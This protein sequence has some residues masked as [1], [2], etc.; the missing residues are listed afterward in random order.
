MG[1]EVIL[2]SFLNKIKQTMENEL[3]N[4][5]EILFSPFTFLFQPL[6]FSFNSLNA[7]YS[8]DLMHSSMF[9]PSAPQ[10]HS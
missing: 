9:S 10:H 3:L 7:S 8:V 2:D 4:T 6:Y 5:H 1:K